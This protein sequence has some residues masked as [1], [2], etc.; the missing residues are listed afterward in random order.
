MS[1]IKRVPKNQSTLAQGDISAVVYNQRAG[2][3]KTVSVGPEFKITP[4]Q[5]TVRA[6]DVSAG[7]Q[8]AEGTLLSIYNNGALAWIT[9]SQSA[10]GAAP[11]GLANGIPLKANDWSYFSMGSN[12]FVRSS[13]AT[14]GVYIV[15]DETSL[16]V[17]SDDD[18]F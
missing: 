4:G 6:L 15:L 16:S 14:V 13:A 7:M 9:F 3:N 1:K 10:I 5:V 17:I 8:I 12:K 11:S 2:A 18:N